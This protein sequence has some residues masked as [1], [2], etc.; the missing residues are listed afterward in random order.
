MVKRIVV[1]ARYGL[2]DWLVQRLTAVYMT[3][4]LVSIGV[5]LLVAGRDYPAWRALLADPTVRFFS[6]LFVVALCWHAWVG[7]RDLWMDYVPATGVRLLL[8][9]LTACAL[10]GYAGWAVQILW[11]L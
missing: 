2:R 7:V 11:R 10:I 6:F 3:L 4:F 8:H 5:A 1:G 9:T